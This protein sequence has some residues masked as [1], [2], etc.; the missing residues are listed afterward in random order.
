MNVSCSNTDL[1]NGSNQ[2]T[3]IM[4]TELGKIVLQIDRENAPITSANFLRNVDEKRYDNSS[5]Y[6]AVRM[7]NQA[8]NEIK[9][10]IIQGGLGPLEADLRLPPI[11]HEAT[12]NTGIL[13][14]NGTISMAR[15]EVG[16]ASSEIFICLG[17][18]PELDYMGS[19]NPDGQGYAAFGHVIKGMD[20]VRKIQGQATE[21]QML[22]EPVKIFSVKRRLF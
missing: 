2:V 10:E 8:E 16:T 19:R 11:D 15:A 5:F 1:L 20:V 4:K 9:I 3:V 7:D 14:E 13:H 17:D 18:Q 22:M 12:S 6:R 21:K